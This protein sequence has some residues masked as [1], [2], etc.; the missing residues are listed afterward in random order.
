M[1]EQ[2]ENL[3]QWIGE[4]ETEVDYVIM[5]SVHRLPAT[6]DRDEAFPKMGDALPLNAAA[7]F[8]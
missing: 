7:E 1:A 5:P 6:L 4:Q 2:L 3:K 8:A